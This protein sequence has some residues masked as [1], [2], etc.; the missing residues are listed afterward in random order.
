MNKKK[1]DKLIISLIGEVLP[2]NKKNAKI[3]SDQSLTLDLGITSIG[4][5]SLAFRIEEELDIDLMPHSDEY[6][7][8]Q[9]I[10]ELQSLIGRIV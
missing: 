3:D 4:L 10:E 1:I 6:S 7:R 2:F 8:L 5:M 9:T